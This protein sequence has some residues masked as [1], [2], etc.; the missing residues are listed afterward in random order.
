MTRGIS[1]GSY[2]R[3]ASWM[4]AMSPVMWRIAVWIAAPLPRFLSWKTG[5]IRG[6][7]RGQ[8]AEDLGR[9]VGRA[10]V[11]DDQLQR[12]RRR[13]LQ[14]AADDRPQRPP[15]VVDRHQDAEQVHRAGGVARRSVRPGAVSSAEARPWAW[16]SG[17]RTHSGTEAAPGPSGSGPAGGAFPPPRRGPPS[18][19]GRRGGRRRWP[20]PSRCRRRGSARSGRRPL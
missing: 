20:P 17:T 10:V 7:L 14:H 12:D 13:A 3:S 9:A 5:L 1:A 2:S 19:R 11:D 16:G 18:D 4:I 8:L 6:V 15:L